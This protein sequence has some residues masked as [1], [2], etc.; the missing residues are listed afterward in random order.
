MLH[1]LQRKL[2]ESVTSNLLDRNFGD[3]TKAKQQI[4]QRQ[5]EEAEMRKRKGEE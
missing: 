1:T 4:E 2:W 3:A 5:R